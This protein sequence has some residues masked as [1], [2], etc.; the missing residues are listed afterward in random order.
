M[1]STTMASHQSLSARMDSVDFMGSTMWCPSYTKQKES[2]RIVGVDLDE[3]RTSFAC[4]PV[5][6]SLF[7]LVM[8]PSSV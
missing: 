1:S 8:S 2:L 6:Q 5:D 7:S 4:D 3:T